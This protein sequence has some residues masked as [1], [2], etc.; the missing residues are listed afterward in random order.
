MSKTGTWGD[1]TKATAE[2]G[3]KILQSAVQSVINLMADIEKTFV[4]LQIRES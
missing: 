3:E 1:A 2:T 4:E